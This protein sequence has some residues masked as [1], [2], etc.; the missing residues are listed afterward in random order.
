M[1]R[2]DRIWT[3]DHL[4]PSK[5]WQ[6]VSAGH[7][8]CVA[9]LLGARRA[10]TRK[11]FTIAHNVWSPTGPQVSGQRDLT[12]RSCLSAMHPGRGEADT[13]GGLHRADGAV[14]KFVS[15]AG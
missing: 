15:D 10:Q 1:S 8:E 3:C 5:S 12:K 9:G 13:L 14:L 7:R 4:T 2:A 6:H 11:T